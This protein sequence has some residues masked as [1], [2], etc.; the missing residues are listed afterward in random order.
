V[1][2]D[3][4]DC[5]LSG[6]ALPGPFVR[7]ELAAVLARLG[8]PPNATTGRLEQ[9]WHALRRRLRLLGGSG[10]PQRVCNQVIVPLADCLGYGAPR[11]QEDIATREGMEDGGWLMQSP[12]GA[13]LRAWSVG[14]ETDL[15]APQRSGRAYRF[16]PTR[17]AQRV[18]LAAGERAGLL[19]NGDELRLLLCDPARPD[20]HI[21]IA[22]AGETGWRAQ[23]RAPDSYRV[24]LALAAPDGLGALADVL[25][26]A[27]MSQTRV[28]RD[29]RLQSRDAIE[30]FLQA[31][32]DHP[33][34]RRL[35]A[36]SD[37]LAGRLW[38]EGLILVYRL[39][40]VL[41]LETASDPARA[42]SF[43]ATGLWR[44]ALSPNRALGPIVRHHLD[45]GADTGRMLEDGLR[46][47]FR[48]FQDGLSC[49]ELCIAP[50]GGAL[51]DARATP[52]LD[53]VAWGER[54]VARSSAVDDAEGAAAR[55]GGLWFARRRGSRPRLRDTAGTRP[56]HRNGTD[57]PPAPREAGGGAAAP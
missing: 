18:L 28:T 26:A 5:A 51:F 29:L 14:R 48:V 10:G 45:Q 41:K 2:L 11:R 24:L 50:L 7:F 33:A 25:D 35:H 40:F 17:S 22:L 37:G 13:K 54:A 30:C 46:L 53:S 19:T 36:G 6:P 15:D 47:I 43:A 32:L 3:L 4:R 57:G 1:T 23:S 55:A 12:R 38:Q 27:R 16:G 39:L 31:V 21:T 49:S 9:S 52:L 20:S 56:R 8:L 34:N 44:N 42:F